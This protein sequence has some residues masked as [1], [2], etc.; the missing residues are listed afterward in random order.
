[1]SAWTKERPTVP[2]AYWSRFTWTHTGEVIVQI[3][4]LV[5]AE[6]GFEAGWFRIGS[7][8]EIYPPTLAIMEFWPI[9]IPAPEAT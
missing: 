3:V 9:P 6:P 4:E 1:M 8:E 5:A 7:E 2:G